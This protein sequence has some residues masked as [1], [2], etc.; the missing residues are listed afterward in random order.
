MSVADNLI[1]IKETI[2]EGVKLVAVSKFHPAEAIMEAYDAG[3]RVFGESRM[4]EIKPK[5]EQLPADIEWHFIGHLQSKK[6]KDIVSYVHTI[7]SVDS[8][9]LL[10]EIEKRAS[11]AQRTVN[12]LLEIHIAQENSKFGFTFENCR[13]FLMQ[14]DWKKCKFARIVGLMGMA[15]DTEDADIVRKEF[16]KLRLFFEELKSTVF[17]GDKQFDQLSM[18][19]S[20]DYKIAIEEGATI[21]R[22]GSSIFGSRQY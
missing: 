22:I 21:V 14:D 19:M 12:C 17:S 3:Q 1:A 2:P 13:Q 6:A 20:H 15:T 11:D 10:Q 5:H 7:H 8:W 18:G 9:K 16:R 4:Q